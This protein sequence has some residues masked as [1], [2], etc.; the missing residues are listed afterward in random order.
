MT[1]NSAKS[2]CFACVHTL[3]GPKPGLRRR[4]CHVDFII[5]I[6]VKRTVSENICILMQLV[7]YYTDF[8]GNNFAEISPYLRH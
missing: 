7:Q 1:V 6:I 8:S 4:G 2:C 3:A 5:L